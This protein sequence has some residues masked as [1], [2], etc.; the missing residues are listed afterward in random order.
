MFGAELERIWQTCLRFET[1]LLN[2]EVR[3][4]CQ[5]FPCGLAAA[6][7]KQGSFVG[8]GLCP[9]AA[10]PT[11]FAWYCVLM[12]TRLA[13]FGSLNQGV[14]PRTA[15]LCSWGEARPGPNHDMY[16]RCRLQAPRFS[17]GSGVRAFTKVT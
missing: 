8:R 7:A 16:G 5:S 1:I 17:G 15:V 13:M 4:S 6:A 14:K 12:C 9:A 11:G 10:G 2:P 3:P